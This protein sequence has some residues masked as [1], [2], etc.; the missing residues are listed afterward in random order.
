M[1]ALVTGGAGFIGSNTVLEL[2]AN[3]ISV[4]IF[5]NLSNSNACAVERLVKL[6]NSIEFV[7]GDI[8]DSTA[9]HT[10]FSDHF[11]DVVFHF[12]GLKSPRESTY[13][14]LEYYDNNV[15]GTLTL[16]TAMSRAK[17]FRMIFSSSASVYGTQLS[18]PLSEDS[19]P[20]VPQNTYGRSKLAAEHI[21]SDLS[22][23]DKR[24]R[25]AALRYFNPIG[26][27]AC[28]LIG[29]APIHGDG[30]L[31]SNIMH[32]ANNETVASL[33]IY[34]C[35]FATS[36]G[37]GMRDYIHVKDLARGHLKALDAITHSSG[38]KVWNLGRGS[39]V[40]VLEMVKIFEKIS[41]KTIRYEFKDRR[42]DEVPECYAD[43]TKAQI[44]L[45]W[46]P[47]FDLEEMISDAWKCGTNF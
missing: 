35:D 13:K 26:A 25:I 43:I 21:L 30:N 12:A 41:G 29:Q 24:W 36:D 7:H 20:C 14:P 27:H 15:N 45:S 40:S 38:F 19:M 32:V 8:R 5:D 46:Q 3:N 47:T 39:P 17:L 4:V 37:T 18:M 44:E 22:I 34:G 2:L 1:K 33:P 9:L 10:L 6:S 16:A 11:F 42:I 28:G 23:S 31:L